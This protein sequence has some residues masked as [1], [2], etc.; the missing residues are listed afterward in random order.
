MN[1]QE[2]NRTTEWFTIHVYTKS[3][4]EINLHIDMVKNGSLKY[5]NIDCSPVY[6]HSPCFNTSDMFAEFVGLG[7][8]FFELRE[9]C[10][11]WRFCVWRGASITGGHPNNLPCT[12]PPQHFRC[13][14]F[15]SLWY[16]LSTRRGAIRSHMHMHFCPVKH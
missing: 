1:K 11:R 10:K 14:I 6:P 9:R 3:Q 2:I 5:I 16:N 12:F 4:T 15:F 13:V 7:S 8:E